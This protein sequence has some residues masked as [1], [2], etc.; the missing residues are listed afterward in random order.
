MDKGIKISVFL[1]ALV[2][3]TAA[4]FW[5]SIVKNT[6]SKEEQPEAETEILP[7]RDTMQYHIVNSPYVGNSTKQNPKPGKQPKPTKKIINSNKTNDATKV[8]VSSIDEKPADKVHIVQKG[9][10]LRKISRIYYDTEKFWEFIQKHNNLS[11][12]TVIIGQKILVPVNP[13]N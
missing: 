1:A 7:N 2:S 12:I 9:D 4:I 8:N 6:G 3:L 11:S 13:E 5:D 10:S